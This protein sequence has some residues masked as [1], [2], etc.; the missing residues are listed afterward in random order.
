[1]SSSYADEVAPSPYHNDAVPKTAETLIRNSPPS[2][3]HAI[4]DV[5][6]AMDIMAD[7]K[8]EQ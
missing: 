2:H 4:H 3:D 8:G 5:P 7:T 1:M 6:L